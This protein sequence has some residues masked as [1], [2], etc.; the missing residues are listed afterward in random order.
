MQI[1]TNRKGFT[2]IE[3][4]VVIAIIGILAT[5]VI[6][7]VNSARNKAK[8]VTIKGTLE[9]LRGAA[10]LSYDTNGNYGSVCSAAAGSGLS[11]SGDFGRINSAIVAQGATVYC[12]MPTTSATSYAAWAGPL[13]SAGGAFCVDS[14]G[15]AK[16]ETASTGASTCQ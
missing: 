4:L 9:S 8:D 14:S 1:F 6:V 15:N 12:Y 3:L 11:S 2:L 13:P 10:E 16:N 5:I 7:N